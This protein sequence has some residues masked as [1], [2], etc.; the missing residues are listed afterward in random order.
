[1]LVKSYTRPNVIYGAYHQGGSIWET[2]FNFGKKMFGTFA[3]TLKKTAITAGEKL[4]EEGGKKL[5]D[6]VTQKLF[7]PEADRTIEKVK[8]VTD[9]L[10]ID[11]EAV[12]REINKIQKQETRRGIG[13]L[14]E[15]RKQYIGD[16]MK[17]LGGG[18][19]Y[20]SKPGE[21]TYF[22]S[23]AATR[24]VCFEKNNPIKGR[25]EPEKQKR[26]GRRRKPAVREREMMAMEDKPKKPRGRPKKTGGAYIMDYM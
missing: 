26:A 21:D 8:P 22:R 1:M 19:W 11:L 12:R 20:E 7:A 17:P 10:G 6:T 15:L 13:K 5:T 25:I 4:L 14:K 23:N 9:T 24:T 3:P 18:A 2:L 16:G